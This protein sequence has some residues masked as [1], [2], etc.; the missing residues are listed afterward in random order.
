MMGTQWELNVTNKNKKP[1]GLPSPKET[2]LDHLGY[3]LPHLIVC[4]PFFAIF[5]LSQW[6]MLH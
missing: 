1:I 5:G 6:L 3:I 4:K 2:K